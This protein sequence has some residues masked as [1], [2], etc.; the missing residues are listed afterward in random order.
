MALS[1]DERKQLQ[2]LM[3]KDKAPDETSDFEI[4]VTDENNRTIRVPYSK[5]KKLL[6]SWGYDLDD[7]PLPP[8]DGNGDGKPEGDPPKK[9]GYWDKK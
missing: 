2:A 9:P 3:E 5:G 7:E 4:E 1:D 8:P 6:K